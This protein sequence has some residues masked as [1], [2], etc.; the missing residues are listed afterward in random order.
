MSVRQNNI[1][2][3]VFCLTLFTQVE[4]SFAQEADSL[5]Q[6]LE[7]LAS[8]Q[9]ATSIESDASGRIYVV[10]ANAST[11]S[12]FD[13]KGVF[14]KSFGGPGLG[15]YEFDEPL[16]IDPTNGLLLF[17]A[18]AG[19]SEIRKYSGEFLH[20]ETILA[21]VADERNGETLGGRVGEDDFENQAEE[22]R[23][24]AIAAAESGELFAIESDRGVVLKWNSTKRLERS[25]GGIE[26]VGESLEDPVDIALG[27]NGMVYVA[28]RG[29]QSIYVFDWFG[30]F[31]S[32]LYDGLAVD[33]RSVSSVENYI[34]M[35][36]PKN[37]IFFEES[38]RLVRNFEIDLDE[39][40]VDMTAV[41]GSIFILTESR[42]LRIP[43]AS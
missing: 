36:L 23:P 33:V 35:V 19:S 30:N 37:L 41:K 24:V 34:A 9:R 17:V 4:W 7:E 43:W 14:Q 13:D 10:D 18:D 38:G 1:W 5:I 40:M 32:K 11:I 39:D 28:D 25:F 6:S 16:D 12:I 3:L 20:L 22:G 21:Q 42:L 8:F 2:H 27:R 15:D 29:N 31:V 26:S